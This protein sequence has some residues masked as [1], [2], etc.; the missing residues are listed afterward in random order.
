MVYP[1]RLQFSLW[2]NQA[3]VTVSS[4]IKHSQTLSIGV[5]K[6]EE[7]IV[8]AGKSHRRLFS[9]HRLNRIATSGNNS[10]RPWCRL[11]V[12]IWL[13]RNAGGGSA[14]LLPMNNLLL[15]F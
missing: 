6:D 3:I 13:R 8:L 1:Q 7:L 4:L 2:L 10:R 15:E 12:A 14:A 9:S 11:Q 5:A